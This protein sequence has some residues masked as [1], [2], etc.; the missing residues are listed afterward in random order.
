MITFGSLYG[1]LVY[2]HEIGAYE[3]AVQALVECLSP[4][5]IILLTVVYNVTIFFS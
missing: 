3:Q 5:F 2:K 4:H 1:A